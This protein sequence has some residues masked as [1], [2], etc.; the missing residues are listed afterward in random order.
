MV[1][2]APLVVVLLM[3]LQL[4][5]QNPPKQQAMGS[6]A[7]MKL[8]RG[9]YGVWN[10]LML[11]LFITLEAALLAGLE[12]K[13]NQWKQMFALPVPRWTIY[14]AKLLVCIALISTSAIVIWIGTIA[15]GSVLERI[16]PQWGI[17]GEIPWLDI[18]R[19]TALSSLAAWLLVALQMWLS[20]R[21]RS[22]ALSVGV[23]MAATVIGFIV[24]QSD[25]WGKFYPWSLPLTSIAG[26]GQ[27]TTFAVTYGVV[28]GIVVGIIG[29]WEM[30]R[31][32]VL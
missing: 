9:I 11:P 25:K 30:T 22:F 31:R 10:F 15:A 24:T 19:M 5:M 28:G 27:N 32:D 16:A 1:L 12:H 14:A 3:F 17:S 26:E 13:A 4:Y 23:G 29:C 18:L 6:E 2:V 21:W 7:W 8:T 20:L